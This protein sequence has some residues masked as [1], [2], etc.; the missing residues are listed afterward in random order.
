MFILKQLARHRIRNKL[1]MGF[2]LIF[3]LI[4][5]IVVTSI[6]LVG[7]I[8]RN[9]NVVKNIAFPQAL[10][11]LEIESLITQIVYG[12]DYSRGSVTMEDLEKAKKGKEN[13]NNEFRLIKESFSG[14]DFILDMISNI[15]DNFKEFYT[16][17]EEI[18]KYNIYQEWEKIPPLIERYDKLHETLLKDVS[19]LKQGG[20][21]GL[22]DAVNDINLITRYT[23]RINVLMGIVGLVFI[24]LLIFIISLS[25]IKPIGMLRNLM[26]KAGS[27]DLTEKYENEC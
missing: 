1:I 3:L 23:K 4:V 16:L 9:L 5:A 17:G 7:R 11:S 12:I 21:D 24:V 20:V 22:N 6:I 2:S 19:K 18:V 14:N 13:L 8:E 27:G 25:I 26:M 15:E 10:K